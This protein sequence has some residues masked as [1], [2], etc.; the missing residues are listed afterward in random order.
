MVDLIKVTSKG[1]ITL[2]VEI[3]KLF[4]INDDS[5]LMIE[6]VGDF[7]LLKKAEIR[8][9]EIQKILNTEAKRKKITRKMLLKA[10]EK[11]KT[12]MWAE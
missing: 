4:G 6:Q 5:Y 2:P 10:L 8:M 9:K 11:T 1:Q 3:R 12:R 7:I